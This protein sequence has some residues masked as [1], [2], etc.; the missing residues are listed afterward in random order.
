MSS[1]LEQRGINPDD[2]QWEDLALCRGL[3]T[4][5]FFEVY[6]QDK[7]AALYVDEMCLRCPV[8]K[9]C[10][11]S[12]QTNNGFGVWGGVYWNAAK[13]DTYRNSHKTP[14]TWKKIKERL[15]ND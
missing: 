1:I 14:D 2:V 7:L 5:L 6:E 9:Q 11:L 4:T 8:M 12:S 13:V 3:P 10:A 15:A